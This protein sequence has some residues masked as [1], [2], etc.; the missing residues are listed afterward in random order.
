ME[1]ELAAEQAGR[2]AKVNVEAGAT[3]DTGAVLVE[4]E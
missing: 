2:V 4:L 3:V 1:N